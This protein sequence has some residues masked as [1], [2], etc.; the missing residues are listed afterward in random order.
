MPRL[1]SRCPEGLTV[2]RKREL[3]RRVYDARHE[4]YPF[5]DDV[6]IFIREWPADNVS[7]DGLLG[8]E[9]IRPVFIMHVPQ[10]GS[11]EARHTMVSRINFEKYLQREGMWS[12]AWVRPYLERPRGHLIP[13]SPYIVIGGHDEC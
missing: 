10:G 2:E 8:N 9:L 11:L 7:Q 1:T 6:R 5:P 12:F 13:V 4:A 3:V